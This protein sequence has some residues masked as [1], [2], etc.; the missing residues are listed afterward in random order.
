[1]GERR[2]LSV[3]VL[4]R[5]LRRP[6]LMLRLWRRRLWRWLQAAAAAPA[7]AAADVLLSGGCGGGAAAA[8]LKTM[9]WEVRRTVSESGG[10]G[11]CP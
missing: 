4:W 10:E 1:M 2:A 3:G 5:V 6:L 11:V 9:I 8:V 7:A